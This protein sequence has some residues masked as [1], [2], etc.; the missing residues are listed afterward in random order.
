MSWS[1]KFILYSGETPIY[2]FLLV[3]D[4]NHPQKG[5]QFVE[6]ESRRANGANYITG[7]YK[8]WDLYL[9][10]KLCAANYQA[11]VTLM[12]SMISSIVTNTLYTLEIDKSESTV[13]SYNVKR[14]V[15]IEFPNKDTDKMRRKQMYK[16]TFKVLG[17]N[18][19][20]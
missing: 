6:H 20:D 17:E 4:T 2:T 18:Q 14:I 19:G 11:L 5:V 9:S 12:D 7:G 10:G 3:Q 8:V 1:P 13:Y 16:I 15:D